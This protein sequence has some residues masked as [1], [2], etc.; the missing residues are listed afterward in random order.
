MIVAEV[1]GHMHLY[2][3]FAKGK[4]MTPSH[5]QWVEATEQ[6]MKFFTDD[7]Y[8]GI[9]WAMAFGGEPVGM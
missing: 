3:S 7:N 8:K 4:M 1:R 5:P 6:N 2:I 9:Q